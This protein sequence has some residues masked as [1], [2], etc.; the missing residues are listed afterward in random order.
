MTEIF[1]DWPGHQKPKIVGP[2]DEYHEPYLGAFS[3]S[4]HFGGNS[5]ASV[6]HLKVVSATV[7]SQESV[8]TVSA[9]GVTDQSV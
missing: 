1:T 3:G 9:Q 5:L 4:L 2:R 7:R 6:E 8:I